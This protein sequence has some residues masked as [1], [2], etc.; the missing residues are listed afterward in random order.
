[1]PEPAADELR[2]RALEH[3]EPATSAVVVVDMQY[4]FVD[5]A[6]AIAAEAAEGAVLGAAELLALARDSGTPVV[7]VI[8]LHRPGRQDYGRQLEIEPE[9][10]V[11]G[12]R[13]AEIVEQLRP[14]RDEAVV[15][16][17]RYDGFFQTDLR[18]VL[19]ELHVENLLFVGVCTELCVA[20]TAHHAKSLDYRVFFV[21]D[22]LAGL[23]PER[24]EAGLR[25]ADPYLGFVV[26][27]ADL[28]QRL[29]VRAREPAAAGR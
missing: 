16:K 29:G 4:D 3:V 26:T 8:T 1:M 25:C 14:A 19:E 17:R 2:A 10:C 9:H 6:S 22:G 12:S 27:L 21:R 15:A 28:T 23:T 24:H 5:P 7:H 11:E 18:L 13:G 20:A